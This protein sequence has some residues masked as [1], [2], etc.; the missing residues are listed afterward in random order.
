[1]L[2]TIPLL[3]TLAVLVLDEFQVAEL[4]RFC[5]LPSV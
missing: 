3:E 4:V 5:V 2:V 1:L